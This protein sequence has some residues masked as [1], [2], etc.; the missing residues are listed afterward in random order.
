MLCPPTN[1]PCVRHV[2][3][4]ESTPLMALSVR[5]LPRAAIFVTI[6]STIT[7]VLATEDRQLCL[8]DY[9]W[10]FHLGEAPGAEKSDFQDKDWRSLD[11]PHDWSIEG[12]YDELAPAAGPGGYL[13]T[14]IGWYRKTFHL[15]ETA[16]GEV[17]SV[18]FDGVYQHS[19]VWINGHE[20]GTHP[21]GY[22][23]FAYDVTPYVNFGTLPNVISVRVDNSVQ[24]LVLRIRHHPAHLAPGHRSAPDRAMGSQHHHALRCR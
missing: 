15:L 20:A 7:C 2:D 19:T 17:V 6:L 23:S 16:R 14:G 5:L 21:Y 24:S 13:P 8:F 3:P 4:Q 11:L 12:P 22:S 18:Q 10:R 9:G 1:S